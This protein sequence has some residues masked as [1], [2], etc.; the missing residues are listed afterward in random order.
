VSDRRIAYFKVIQRGPSVYAGGL[1]GVDERGWP[2]DFRHTDPVQPSRLQQILYGRGLDAHVKQDVIFR[3]LSETIDLKQV[4]LMLV[5][6]QGYLRNAGKIPLAY[7]TE[8]LMSPLREARSLEA[9]S[10]TEYLVQLGETGSP[11]RFEVPHAD[12]AAA[13]QVADLLIASAQGGLDPIEPF[14]RV[15]AAIEHVCFPS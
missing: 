6:E 9:L 3:H 1:M 13:R 8:T 15:K 7:V 11:L 14:A 2:V 12:E 10:G 4:G 5:D